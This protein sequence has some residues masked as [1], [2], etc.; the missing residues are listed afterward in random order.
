LCFAIV[1]RGR[2]VGLGRLLEALDRQCA[3]LGVAAVVRVVVN[4]ALDDAYRATLAASAARR[5]RL[6]SRL[7]LGPGIPAARNAL[8]D[9][10]L[11]ER[12][13]DACVFL[14]D[15]EQPAPD[16]LS[17]LLALRRAH[18][19]TILTGPVLAAPEGEAGFLARHGAYDR[20]RRLP[21]GT[22]AGE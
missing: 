12:P 5:L 1:S 14:D 9:W 19:D 21:S 16:W 17:R 18:P 2:A 10:L 3:A 13:A 4:Q 20:V 6:A 22:L 11:E 7:C 15:D 8:V